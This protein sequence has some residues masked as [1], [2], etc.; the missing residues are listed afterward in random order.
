MQFQYKNGLWTEVVPLDLDSFDGS[1][2]INE[3]YSVYME[4]SGNTPV[5]TCIEYVTVQFQIMDILNEVDQTLYKRV[6]VVCVPLDN[7][8]R[9]ILCQG[10]VS[11][12]I[13]NVEQRKNNRPFAFPDYRLRP[14]GVR[15][16]NIFNTLSYDPL[17]K[18]K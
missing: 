3:G 18:I 10:V 13:G 12:T 5:N 15:Y 4:Y 9:N 2:R 11:G 7:T 14:M 17:Q 8:N 16:N 1:M 6:R